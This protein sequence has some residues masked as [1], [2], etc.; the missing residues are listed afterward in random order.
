MRV[1]FSTDNPI[2]TLYNLQHKYSGVLFQ[3]Y[4]EYLDVH[5]ELKDVAKKEQEKKMEQNKP[6]KR[7]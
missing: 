2:E 1:I 5:E 3:D 7:G 6:K 4:L